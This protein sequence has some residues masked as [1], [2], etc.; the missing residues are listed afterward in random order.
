MQAI[1]ESQPCRLGRPV[2]RPKKAS[3]QIINPVFIRPVEGIFL[4]LRL[5]NFPQN[6]AK[7]NTY[8]KKGGTHD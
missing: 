1:A 6:V 7:P 8:L 4:H 2:R 3:L 5:K